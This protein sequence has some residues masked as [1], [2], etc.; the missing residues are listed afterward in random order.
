MGAP[1]TRSS[2]LRDVDRLYRQLTG[3]IAREIGATLTP[4][5][6]A[7]LAAARSVDPGA[8]EAYLQGEFHW[9]KLTRE[10]LE[11]A[12][13]Y[14]TLALEKDSSYAPA[15]EGLAVVW[16]ARQQM[17]ITHPAEA[18]PKARLAA[19]HAVK[20]DDASAGAHEALAMIRTWTDWD[21]PGADVEWRRALELDPNRATAHAYYAHY[22]ATTGHVGEALPHSQRALEVDPFNPLFH[23]MYAMVLAQAHRFQEAVASAQKALVL[24]PNLGMARNVLQHAYVALNM[25]D[26]MVEVQRERNAIDP[27]RVAV[28]EA[29][30]AEGG[31][32]E[33]F[34]RLGDLL[35]ARYRASGGTPAAGARVSDASWRGRVFM[36]LAISHRY[37]YAGVYEQAI[38]WI[39][40]AYAIHE[41]SIPYI[42]V[43]P[44]YDP[45]RSD[46]RF[47]AL[48]QRLHLPHDRREGRG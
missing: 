7:R 28:F 25:R 29:G 4:E 48:V 22:L 18:G 16:G 37:I 41:P 38:R 27:E 23:G 8:Y 36:P 20:L 1:V 15:Y 19:E 33:A 9:K 12:E 21:W 6:E 32:E 44:L 11:L 34:L 10:D 40:E 26:E 47:Q 45:L 3:A 24:Q 43:D 13:R 39:E 14:F 46:P 31:Y 17:Q 30:L 35:A 5:V 42:A 2:H